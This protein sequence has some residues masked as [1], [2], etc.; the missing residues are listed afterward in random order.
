MSRYIL[1]L[2]DACERRDREKWDRIEKLLDSYGI[3]SLVGVIPHCED[4]AMAHY[5]YDALFWERVHEWVSKG[6]TVALHGYN[7]VYTTNDGGINPVNARSEFAG[8]SLDIQMDKIEKGVGILNSHGIDPSV[9]FAPSHT[10]DKNTLVALKEKSNIR[11]I[12]DT[13]ANKPYVNDGIIFVPQQSGRVRSLPFSVVTFCY[14]P[15][16]MDDNMFYELECFIKKNKNRFI[17]FPLCETARKKSI[18]DL[19]LEKVYFSRR[20]K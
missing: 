11:Y 1:R 8:V 7:H 2:D 18:F 5:E 3:K 12:S 10:F 4:P 6:W 17:S 9:F 15:N 13:V 19:I 16:A 14:H 20:K